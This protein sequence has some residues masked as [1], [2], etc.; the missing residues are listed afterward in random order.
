[1]NGTEPPETVRTVK[2]AIE[3]KAS[4]NADEVY[5]Q[6]ADKEITYG[7]LD[8]RANAIA[9]GLQGRVNPGDHV[10]LFLYNSPEY[11]YM[12]FALAKAGAVATPIDTRFAS[13]TLAHILSH[14][15]A[16]VIFFDSSTKESYESVRTRVPNTSTE[17]FVGEQPA[18]RSY[19]DFDQLLDG[20][21]S[22]PPDVTVTET[23]TFS[24]T[25]VQQ[26]ASQ[27]PK[28]VL[29]PHFSYVNTG[30]ESSRNLFELSEEDRILSPLPLYSIFPVQVGVMAPLFSDVQFVLENQFDPERFWDQISSYDATVFLYLSRMLSVLSNQDTEPEGGSTSAEFALGHS[31]GF[32]TDEDVFRNFERRFGVTILEL[33][34][35]TQSGS[36]ATANRLDQRKIGSVGRPI[37]YAKVKIVD[38]NDRSVEPGQTGEIVIRSTRS[39]AM[40]KGYYNDPERTVRDW[41][42]RWIHTGDYGY[43]DDDGYLHFIGDREDSIYRASITSRISS[44][45]IM[46]VINTHPDVRNSVVIGVDDGYGNEEIKAIVVTN[47]GS[48]ISPIDIH[49]HCRQHLPYIKIPRYIELRDE[50]PKTPSGRV[51]KQQLQEEGVGDAWDRER[52]YE[53]GR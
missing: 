9:N 20:E 39:N 38:E 17:Y 37:S 32:A 28:G 44:L 53:F 33:Y 13:D 34:G 1:M 30:W 11:V 51:R 49:E 45:E 43:L 50:L 15:D 2:E 10:C 8:R 23:D 25:Y 29:L 41:R 26:S 35:N 40:M 18:D 4:E 52:G 14:S 42:N 7:E 31:F 5:F 47:E 6:Y 27:Q 24:L 12:Y 36:L 21:Q 16:N 46:S 22:S 19:Y 3:R 48:D